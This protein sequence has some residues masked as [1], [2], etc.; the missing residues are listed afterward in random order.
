MIT[1]LDG[2]LALALPPIVQGPI[3]TLAMGVPQEVSDCRGQTTSATAAII[4]CHWSTDRLQQSWNELFLF[5][6]R[7]RLAVWTTSVE[8]A[9]E[10]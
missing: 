8:E 5:S 2:A 4:C 6:E 7:V 1:S 3:D 10:E 9:R